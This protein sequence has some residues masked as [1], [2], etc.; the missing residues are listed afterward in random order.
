MGIQSMVTRTDMQG[1]RVGPSQRI[2]VEEALRVCTIN[3]ARA[4][5]EEGSRDRSPRASW[6]TS[7][8]LA[9]DPHAVDPF[10][11]KEIEIVRTGRRRARDLRSLS[12]DPAGRDARPLGRRG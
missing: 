3:G 11:I 1:P 6:R 7:V 9:E 8:I 4:G 12:G 5:F 2:T 10:A